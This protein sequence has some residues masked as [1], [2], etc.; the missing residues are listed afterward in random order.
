MI[1]YKDKTVQED[2]EEIIKSDQIAW[3]KLKDKRVL[4]TGASGMLATYLV[5]VLAKL[6]ETFNYNIQILATGR[7]R[8]KLEKKFQGLTDS[9][10]LLIQHDVAT[11]FAFDENIDY[12]IHAASNASPHFILTDPVGI[13]RANVLGTSNLLEFSRS[14]KLENFLFLSTR[15]IYGKAISELISEESY[16][17]FDILES[18]ACYPESKRM[19]ETLLKS[20]SDQY[21]LPFTIARIA[22]S[23]GPGMELAGDGRIMS[24]L[25]SNV[26]NGENIILKS[27]G[28]AERAF[29]YLSD[30]VAGIFTILLNGED[31]NAY[32][33]AN[34]EEPIE[35]RTLAQK[36]VDLF[37]EKELKVMFDIPETMSKGYSQ[38]GR[39]RLDTRKLEKLGWK[40]KVPLDVGL[41]KTVRSFE[42][43]NG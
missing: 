18:R 10:V 7:N 16:G 38:M 3:D 35:I 22:H 40:K 2:L 37:A 4:I 9:N 25:L 26:V 32:N 36:L 14:Q 11:P 41:V 13:I 17:G 43:K 30:A 15:E 34:E 31:G 27:D 29:C 6:N 39:T 21:S 1:N 24:D 5:Y 42:E 33:I 12:I 28:R 8:G 19:A 20:Y 23:Y